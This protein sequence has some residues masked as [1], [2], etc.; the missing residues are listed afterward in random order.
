MAAPVYIPIK[1]NF[2]SFS[3]HTCQNLLL[4][5]FFFLIAILI[6]VR[7][8]SLSVCFFFFSSVIIS[9]VDH[10]LMCLLVIYMSSLEKCLFMPPAHFLTES[11]GFL[12][13]ELNELFIYFGY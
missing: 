4:K 1:K 2:L 7:V 11:F 5:D 8:I 12:N 6:G 3:P 9:D 13:T 10:F